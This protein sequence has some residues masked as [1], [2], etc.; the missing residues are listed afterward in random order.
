M[1]CHVPG[2]PPPALSCPVSPASFLL[3]APGLPAARPFF[4][5]IACARA[6]L[7]APAR[8]ARLIARASPAEGARLPFVPLGFFTPARN[9]RRSGLRMPLPRDLSYHGF[10]RIK[11][12]EKNYFSISRTRPASGQIMSRP[13]AGRAGTAPGRGLQVRALPSSVQPGRGIARRETWP[14]GEPAAASAALGGEGVR[15]RGPGG[16]C[17]GDRGGAHPR[18]LHDYCRRDRPSGL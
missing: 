3:P 8:F 17:P 4:A 13:A 2:R 18:P 11:P 15:V 1:R 7:S 9:R 6:R 5:R 12:L 16:P 14:S 10:F